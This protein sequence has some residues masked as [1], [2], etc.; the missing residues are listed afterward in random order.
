MADSFRA[1]RDMPLLAG[2]APRV[3]QGAG[4]MQ[5]SAGHDDITRMR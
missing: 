3:L 1:G 5:A 2:H 4:T